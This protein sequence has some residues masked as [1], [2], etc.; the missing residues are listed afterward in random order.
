MGPPAQGANR[1][2]CEA[3]LNVSIEIASGLE[4]LLLLA[5]DLRFR[6]SLPWLLRTYRWWN[7]ELNGEIGWFPSNFVEAMP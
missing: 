5:S 1:S 3:V 2:A 7:G 6:G 4:D